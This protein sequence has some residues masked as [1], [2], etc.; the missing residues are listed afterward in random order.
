ML[1]AAGAPKARCAVGST[2]PAAVAAAAA[3]LPSAPAR[4]R[5]GA[6]LPTAPARFAVETAGARRVGRGGRAKIGRR[7]PDVTDKALVVAGARGGAVVVFRAG[8]V[9]TVTGL[10]FA[11]AR[12]AA[13]NPACGA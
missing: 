6:A 4:R 3:L 1:R 9:G 10:V 13:V 12:R 2:A 5:G 11:A 7:R 8:G